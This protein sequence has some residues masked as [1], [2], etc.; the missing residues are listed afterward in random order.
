ME[1]LYII[2]NPAFG[3]AGVLESSCP[4]LYPEFAPGLP[5]PWPEVRQGHVEGGQVFRPAL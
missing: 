1:R 2:E 4:L 3:E 5:V